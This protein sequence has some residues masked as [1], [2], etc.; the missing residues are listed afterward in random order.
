MVYMKQV[1]DP[2]LSVWY[3][4]FWNQ[5]PLFTQVMVPSMISIKLVKYSI[6]P[7]TCQCHVICLSKR[8][9]M[10]SDLSVIL[11]LEGIYSF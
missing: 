5:V 4:T 6:L 9:S 3:N 8:L 11:S 1:Y 10:Q 7:Q 2:A